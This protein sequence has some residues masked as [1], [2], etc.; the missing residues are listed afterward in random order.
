MT[1]AEFLKLF[2]SP[3]CSGIVVYYLL[4]LDRVADKKRNS[5]ISKIDENT[6]IATA[7][8]KDIDGLK[9]RVGRQN[10]RI[11]KLETWRDHHMEWMSREPHGRTD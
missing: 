2:L 9:E 3:I 10:G 7:S 11:D 4:K 5:T 8:A 6:V 1:V